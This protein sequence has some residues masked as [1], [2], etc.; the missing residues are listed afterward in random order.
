[1]TVAGKEVNEDTLAVEAIRE[2]VN[3][4]RNFL[5]NM[6]TMQHLRT[7]TWKPILCERNTCEA[8]Q[9]EGHITYGQK[10][11]AKAKDLYANHEVEPLCDEY[12]AAVDA[13]VQRAIDMK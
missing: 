10:A 11:L 7:E 1:Y 2:V 4:E 6:H 13:A 8:W 9:T 3:G 12:A 5:G